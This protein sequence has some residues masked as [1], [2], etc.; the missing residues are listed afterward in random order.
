MQKHYHRRVYVFAND[1]VF[2]ASAHRARR[3]CADNWHSE[4]KLFRVVLTAMCRELR[5]TQCVLEF[6][7]NTILLHRAEEL[8]DCHVGSMFVDCV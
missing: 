5:P 8:S 2:S 7:S 4:I 1:Q 6:L 3:V